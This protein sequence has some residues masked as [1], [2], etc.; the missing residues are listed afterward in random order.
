MNAWRAQPLNE[1]CTDRP[2]FALFILETLLNPFSISIVKYIQEHTIA[3]FTELVVSTAMESSALEQHIEK[4]CEA[5]V[6]NP[7]SEIYGQHFAL[8]YSKL[9]KASN[10]SRQLA[11]M[12]QD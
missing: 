9:E 6:L 8:N 2:T 4:M 3:S 12:Y 5:G 7:V 1:L 11:S 10:I